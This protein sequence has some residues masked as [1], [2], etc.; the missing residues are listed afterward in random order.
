M[1]AKHIIGSMLLLAPLALGAQD[2]GKTE[3]SGEVSAEGRKVEADPASSKFNEYQDANT[4]RPVFKL[5]LNLVGSQGGYLELEG[6]NLLRT[7]QSLRLSTGKFGLWSLVLDRNEIPHNLSFK[8]MTPFRDQGDGL[9]TVDSTVP[10]PNRVLTGTAAQL[11]ANDAA[12]AAWLPTQLRPVDLGTQRDR[13]GATLTLTPMEGLKF[14]LAFVDE[15]KDGT[16]ISYGPIG[17]RPPR[18]LNIQLPQPVDFRT[19]ELRFE[20]EY[21]TPR[22][23]VAA[24]HAVSKFDNQIDTFTWQNVYTTY[25]GSN[26]FDQ[27]NYRVGTFGRMALAP[28]NTYQNTQVTVGVNLPWSSR[29]TASLALGKMEQDQSLQPYATSN[30]NSTTTDFSNP[31]ELNRASA[32]TE[33]TTKRLN[34]EYS[35][36]PWSRVGLRAYARRYSLNNRTPM[37]SWWYVT[38]DTMPGNAA[39]TVTEPTEFNKRRNLAYSYTQDTK[40]LEASAYLPFWHS[41]L[42]LTAEQE[43]FDRSHREAD[44]DETTL[45]LTY[46]AKPAKWLSLRAKVLQGKRDGGAYDYNAT[47]RSYWYEQAD[48]PAN[49]ALASPAFSFVNH[50]DMRKFDV[51]DRSRR[52]YDLSAT[53]SPTAALDIALTYRSRKDDFDSDVKAIQPLLNNPYAATPADA[54]SWTPGIQLG[55]LDNNSTRT[56]VDISYAAGERLVLN[57][58]FSREDRDA[59]QRSIEFNENFKLNPTNAGLATNE[60]GPWTRAGSEWM[61]KT[62]D[63]SET[64]GLGGAFDIL[65]GKLRFSVD[66]SRT[67]GTVDIAYS[68]FGAESSL[69]PGTVLADTYQFAFRSPSTVETRQATLSAHL[70][71]QF[72]KQLAAGL[73]YTY[74]DYDLSDWMQEANTPWTESVGSQYLLRDTSSATSTQWGNRLISMGSYLAPT[75]KAHYVALSVSYR[76]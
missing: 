59:S 14:S 6:Q 26:T 35:I 53:F 39:A 1:S 33:I 12:T 4:G 65:P 31:A 60:L 52:E 21:A 55:L 74:D 37:G 51:S 38:N 23:Q 10:L 48:L 16:K 17:D 45:K 5:D 42:T 18:S 28:D 67:K 32:D 49:E 56:A 43:S 75:Y 70:K 64:Y 29:F 46:R 11:L 8:A 19:R 40:G 73:H 30:F 24:S 62:D 27:W 66:Y 76:F 71:F 57:A 25:N 22:Y 9:Y 54:Q 3:F 36:R 68:G 47:A 20:A 58:F 50:P 15:R 34:L 61:A 63:K 41:S 72:S 2:A 7:D 44:T 13:T 69:T